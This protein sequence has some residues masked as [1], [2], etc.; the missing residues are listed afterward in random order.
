MCHFLHELFGGGVKV[1][2]N[3]QWNKIESHK[4]LEVITL[5]SCVCVFISAPNKRRCEGGEDV[6]LVQLKW[7]GGR[8]S[9]LLLSYKVRTK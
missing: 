7:A 4:I 1:C 8:I 5:E 2:Q 6:T 3:I 9:S